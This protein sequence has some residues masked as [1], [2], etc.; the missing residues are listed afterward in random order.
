MTARRGGYP[1]LTIWILRRCINQ[2]PKANSSFHPS[3][4]GK[5]VPASAGK[6]KVGMVHSISGWMRGVQLKCEIPWERVSYLSAL[7]VCSRRGAIR[8]HVYLYLYLL[9]LFSNDDCRY[10]R[11]PKTDM[12]LARKLHTLD[13]VELR[14]Q[15]SEDG[16]CLRLEYTWSAYEGVKVRRDDF[17]SDLEFDIMVILKCDTELQVCVMHYVQCDIQII[18]FSLCIWSGYSLN[19]PNVVWCEHVNVYCHIMFLSFRLFV[20]I[21]F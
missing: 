11:E 14:D 13:A 10:A 7:E 3:G 21:L 9:V 18:T 5:W 6:A 1:F 12:T 2:P 17:D 8:I 4:V 19:S 15:L 20:L 16:F